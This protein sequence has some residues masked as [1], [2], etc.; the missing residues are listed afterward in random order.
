MRL[1]SSVRVAAGFAITGLEWQLCPLA[2]MSNAT[3]RLLSFV[4]PCAPAAR[5]CALPAERPLA[6]SARRHGLAVG[7]PHLLARRHAVRGGPRA[8]G[9]I[10]HAGCQR[11]GVCQLATV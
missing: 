10:G 1:V 11:C 2:N 9:G 3:G 4:T 8:G 5:H 6:Q 7:E